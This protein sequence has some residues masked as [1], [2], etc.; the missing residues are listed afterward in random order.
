V[1]VWG[2]NPSGENKF[3]LCVLTVVINAVLH[4][5]FLC[6]CTVSQGL[7]FP[8]FARKVMRSV[9]LLP[10]F[11]KLVTTVAILSGGH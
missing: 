5:E 9:I 1:K 3:N 6:E 2:S 4:T 11:C 10:W 7:I 8:V